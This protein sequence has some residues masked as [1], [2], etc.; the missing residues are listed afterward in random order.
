MH[1]VGF[2]FLS[3]E[4]LLRQKDKS[5]IAKWSDKSV[6]TIPFILFK[7]RRTKKVNQID[8][9]FCYFFPLTNFLWNYLLSRGLW[10]FFWGGEVGKHLILCTP[11][12][13]LLLMMFPSPTPTQ[14]YQGPGRLHGTFQK[15]TLT[16]ILL[17]PLSQLTRGYPC[18]FSPFLQKCAMLILVDLHET[19]QSKQWVFCLKEPL[20]PLQ[21]ELKRTKKPNFSISIFFSIL[22]QYLTEP[23]TF[24][25]TVIYLPFLP[26]N[27][28]Q[29]C[30]TR[31]NPASYILYPL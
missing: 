13:G 28:S 27:N 19:N 7:K 6:L 18:L 20:L 15:N 11:L 26:V 24:L 8:F 16:L 17:P 14:L 10:F 22:L 25:E 29:S 1:W 31:T 9:V 23:S 30:Q 5:R 2:R 3:R 12:K 4:E 21:W